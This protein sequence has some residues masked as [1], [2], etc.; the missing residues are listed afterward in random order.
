MTSNHIGLGSSQATHSFYT[1]NAQR[2]LR[3]T[4]SSI[5]G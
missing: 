2:N 3:K 5:A 4:T 1:T